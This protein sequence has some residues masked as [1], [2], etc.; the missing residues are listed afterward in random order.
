MNYSSIPFA[1]LEMWRCVT[2]TFRLRVSCRQKTVHLNQCIDQQFMMVQMIRSSMVP[3]SRYQSS[4]L[5][6]LLADLSRET[7]PLFQS[8]D[9]RFS[10]SCFGESPGIQFH[11]A[12]FLGLWCLIMEITTMAT[13]GSTIEINM[14]YLSHGIELE[15][16]SDCP[17]LEQVRVSQ[18]KAFEFA[19][20]LLPVADAFDLK[21]PLGGG[22][23]QLNIAIQP[24]IQRRRAA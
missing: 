11:E 2:D 7:K 18:S 12:D 8:L 20:Q 4:S 22:A 21:C 6:N 15:I 14:G 16:G 23:I 13:S 19:S 24:S 9:L 10:Y 1:D 17:S 3:G 5:D